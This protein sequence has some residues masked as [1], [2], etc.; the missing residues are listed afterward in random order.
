MEFKLKSL[1]QDSEGDNKPVESLE[2]KMKRA[3]KEAAAAEAQ[4]AE[5]VTAEP[6]E[7]S[8]SEVEATVEDP[9][10]EEEIPQREAVPEAPAPALSVEKKPETPKTSPPV[11]HK[12]KSKL[13]LADKSMSQKKA[14][15]TEEPCANC[16]AQLREG[17]VICTACGTKVGSSK[18]LKGAGQKS[19]KGGMIFLIIIIIATAVGAKL[20]GFI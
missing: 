20:G 14:D 15:F 13:Q 2:E 17:D 10:V 11:A 5:Q 1:G 7:Q 12:T 3:E 19:S 9:V 16:G 6:E 8:E 4:Q 18:K